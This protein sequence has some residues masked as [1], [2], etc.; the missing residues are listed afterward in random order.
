MSILSTQLVECFAAA[1]CLLA[2]AGCS[3]N[4]KAYVSGVVTADGAPAE[5]YVLLF[6]PTD[7]IAGPANARTGPGGTYQARTSRTIDW[8]VPGTFRIEVLGP[9]EL[10]RGSGSP[11]PPGAVRL[12]KRY[13]GNASE[14]SATVEPGNNTLNFELH[15]KGAT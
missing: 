10:S 15:L 3:S 4:D 13:R 14:L 6:M 8:V 11:P 2:V 1:A 12:P 9:V 7:G 5:G